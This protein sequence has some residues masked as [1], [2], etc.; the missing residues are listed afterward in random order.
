MWKWL[1]RSGRVLAW[2]ALLTI[3]WYIASPKIQWAV[4]KTKNQ[5]T[6]NM[7][8]KD[9]LK[10]DTL[11]ATEDTETNTIMDLLSGFVDKEEFNKLMHKYWYDSTIHIDSLVEPDPVMYR[12]IWEMHQKYGNPY[13]TLSQASKHM[14][15]WKEKF[16]RAAFDGPTNT[17]D[18]HKL[19]SLKIDFLSIPERYLNDVY[20]N[21]DVTLPVSTNKDR[22]R[23]L[24]NNRIA[25]LSH[26]F[27]RLQDWPIRNAIDATRDYV[28]VKGKDSMLYERPWAYEY[29]AH[30]VTQPKLTQEFINLY[31]KYS[32][33]NNSSV[34]YKIWLFY[35]WYFDHYRDLAKAEE[36]LQKAAKSKHKEA[37]YILGKRYFKDYMS[38]NS[39]DTLK[40]RISEV[41]S[42]TIDIM[43]KLMSDKDNALHNTLFH[44]WQSARAWSLFAYLKVIEICKAS[45]LPD[46]RKIGIAHAL[47]LIHRR[48]ELIKK[49]SI[50]FNNLQRKITP[51]ELVKVYKD[52]AELYEADWQLQKAEIWRTKANI[53]N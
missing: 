22:Q 40:A 30:K 15:T 45:N 31:T 47:E 16:D 18:L 21:N 13:V 19:D 28:L 53:K 49:N 24:I 17:I 52:L 48:D 25:E 4:H 23:Y 39:K 1:R 32:D 51:L 36:W 42:T 34:Q 46:S 10:G 8:H 27:Y 29:N 12:V 44:F 33:V 14:I 35:N 2:G 20:N 50:A 37:H 26:S 5:L 11:Y 9:I 3:A 7:Q 41:D 43:D 6:K 38:Y